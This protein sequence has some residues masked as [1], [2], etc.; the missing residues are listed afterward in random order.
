MAVTSSFT[1]TT[2]GVTAS[3]E[4]YESAFDG[5]FF[6]GFAVTWGNVQTERVPGLIQRAIV[7]E[8][9]AA[10][11]KENGPSGGAATGAVFSSDALRGNSN[12]RSLVSSVPV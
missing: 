1:R 10:S 5:R 9:S 2:L 7:T 11:V 6:A 4:L 12:T 3:F 8:T